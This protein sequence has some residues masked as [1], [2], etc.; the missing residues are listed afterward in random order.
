MST[1]WDCGVDTRLRLVTAPE[2]LPFDAEYIRARVIRA[3][4][5]ETER[6]WIERLI[7]AFTGEA[8]RQTGRAL[9]PQTWALGLSRFP[10]SGL[11]KIPKAPLIEV[12]G[13][14]YLDEDG[15]LTTATSP[16]SAGFQIVES[17]GM[18]CAEL[19][20]LYDET[21]PETR[22]QVDAV[23]LTF[24]CGF[25]DA[26]DP[27]YERI[28]QGIALGVGELYK[29]R[30]LSVHAV[31]NTASRLQLAHFWRQVIW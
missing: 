26:N 11:I 21:W 19:R 14:S 20:P 1:R 27:E 13:L 5:V 22:C 2:R 6:D 10:P 23:T 8:E 24:R 25:E 15:V 12:T 7:A 28:K 3:A 18:K 31:H 17:A 4:D 9:E 29:Q 16:I 30:T